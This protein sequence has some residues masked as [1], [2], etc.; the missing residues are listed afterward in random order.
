MNEQIRSILA[1]ETTKTSKIRQLY[2]LGVPRAEIAR[3][4]TNGNYGFVV[5]A[6]R[7]MREREGGLNIHPATTALDYTFNR[8]FGIEI[9]AYNCSRERLARE[10][11]EA[12]IEVVVEGYNHTTRPQWTLVTVT[13]HSSWSVRSWSVKPACGNWRRSAGC[14]T[15]VT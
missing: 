11:R 3:M 12:G 5:N 7:R 4:V 15:C 14:L 13:P 8:K 10:L 6:L 2:L 1:Q 9:E